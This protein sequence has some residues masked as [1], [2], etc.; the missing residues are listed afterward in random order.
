V[1]PGWP[2]RCLHPPHREFALAPLCTIHRR[3]SESHTAA[4]PTTAV[5][6]QGRGARPDECT[7]TDRIP[8]TDSFLLHS[9]VVYLSHWLTYREAKRQPDTRSATTSAATSNNDMQSIHYGGAVDEIVCSLRM[10]GRR[11]SR[12]LWFGAQSRRIGSSLIT[13]LV[14]VELP[15]RQRPIPA[16]P[17]PLRN[18]R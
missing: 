14:R 7:S 12:R 3:R 5:I 10:T 18:R 2:N 8:I 16:W 11:E 1:T 13:R 6:T 4:S 15:L 17:R 9:F